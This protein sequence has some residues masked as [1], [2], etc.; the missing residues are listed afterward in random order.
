MHRRIIIPTPSPG[1]QS[2]R[3]AAMPGST[4]IHVAAAAGRFFDAPPGRMLLA[5]SGAVARALFIALTLLGAAAAKVVLPWKEVGLLTLTLIAPAALVVA[6]LVWLGMVLYRALW[7]ERRERRYMQFL[8][9][10]LDA[11]ME[12]ED[13]GDAEVVPNVRD[14]KYWDRLAFTLLQRYYETLNRTRSREAAARAISREACVRE[15]ICNQKE[16]NVVNRLLVARGLRRGRKRG[17]IPRTF[18]EAWRIWQ[19]K[20]AQTNR[21]YID[22]HGDWIPRE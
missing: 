15:G 6:V 1:R 2:P 5:E 3:A 7:F 8:D 19:E 13:E 16:W 10:Q 21:W 20:S 17:L 22:D 18:E 14:T 9:V 4:D 11:L 12:E